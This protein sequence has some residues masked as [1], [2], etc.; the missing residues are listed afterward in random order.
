MAD[1]QRVVVYGTLRPGDYNYKRFKDSIIVVEDNVAID[2]F[3]MRSYHGW[4]PYVYPVSNSKKP[5]ICTVIDYKAKEDNFRMH[6]MELGARYYARNLYLG[7]KLGNAIIYCMEPAAISDEHKL[8][9]SGD[10]FESNGLK[11]GSKT[12][13]TK[14]EA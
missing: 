14:Q 6:L 4:Y 12:D 7:P 8:I 3:E 1:V 10:W 5:I 11:N 2:G 9:A 13:T